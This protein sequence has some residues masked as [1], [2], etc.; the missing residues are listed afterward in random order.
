MSK[1]IFVVR[2]P[3]PPWGDYGRILIH[4]IASHLPREDGIIQLERTGPFIPPLSFPAVGIV[5]A[6][7]GARELLA[8]S[9]LGDLQWLPV[10]RRHIV[11]S[12]WPSWDL[13]ASNPPVMPPQ[14]EPEGYVLGQPHDA[15][16]AQATPDLWE[17]QAARFGSG[18]SKRVSR[19]NSE[20]SLTLEGEP[21]ELFRANGLR[22][23]FASERAAEWLT[24]H[25]SEWIALR[26]V[27]FSLRS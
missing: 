15:E 19:G 12:D 25:F 10:I 22:H 9:T 20:I 13:A 2:P 5:I 23:L 4:G 11:H 17:L 21:P 8:G 3:E 27:T 1:Q 14:G 16:L 7:Q 6:T 26:P 18:T 24:Q